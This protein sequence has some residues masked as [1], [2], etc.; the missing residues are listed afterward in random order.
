VNRPPWLF[1]VAGALLVLALSVREGLEPGSV[2]PDEAGEAPTELGFPDLVMRSAEITQFRPDGSLHYRLRAS[3][4]THYP[5]AAHTLLVEPVLTL[6]DP[7]QPPWRVSARQGR[8]IGT[9][10][11]LEA[12][13]PTLAAGEVR[14]E[15]VVLEEEVRVQ[16]PRPSGEGVELATSRLTLYPGREYAVTNRPVMIRTLEGRTTAARLEADL[17]QGRFVLAS[18][19]SERVRSTLLPG[20]IR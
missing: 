8:V 10:R 16:R 2:P 3:E 5:E 1:L 18:S 11:L 13:A 19:A 14:E 15:T 6:Y 9:T 4:I 12:P 17:A 7:G 20:T